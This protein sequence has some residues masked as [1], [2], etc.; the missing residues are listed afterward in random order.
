MKSAGVVL[1]E[2]VRH[3]A[4][5]VI[6]NADDNEF[7][8]FILSLFRLQCDVNVLG[9]GDRWIGRIP[10]KRFWIAQALEM[11]VAIAAVLLGFLVPCQSLLTILGDANPVLV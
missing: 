4:D 1:R 6:M 7:I 3:L 10:L 8:Q 9:N 5:I 11:P 2:R